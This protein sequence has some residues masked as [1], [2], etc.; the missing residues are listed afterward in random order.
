LEILLL[1][2]VCFFQN[3]RLDVLVTSLL[4]GLFAQLLIL[5]CNSAQKADFLDFM[6]VVKACDVGVELCF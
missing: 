6:E 4:E 5:L 3:P 1:D 2:L